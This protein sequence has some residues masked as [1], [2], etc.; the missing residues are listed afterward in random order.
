MRSSNLLNSLFICLFLIVISA[1][2]L[3]HFFKLAP[4]ISLFE[5]RNLAPKPVSQKKFRF[6][7][8]RKQFEP[9]YNDHF[10][11]RKLLLTA[12]NRLH[13]KI[14]KIA[15]GVVFGS[16]DWLF[17]KQGVRS[18]LKNPIPIIKD[19]CGDAPFSKHE[20]DQWCN[21]LLTNW[22]TL[23]EHGIKYLYLP[24]PN[25]HRIYQQKLPKYGRCEPALTRLDQL[26]DHLTKITNYPIIDL[27]SNF[28]Q[29]ANG[30]L[31]FQRDTHWNN[32]GVFIAYQ[33]IVES[34]TGQLP[35]RDVSNS[36]K[37]VNAHKQGCD[38]ALMTGMDRQVSEPYQAVKLTRRLTRKIPN[39]Y[40]GIRQRVRAFEQKDKSLSTVLVFHDSFGVGTFSQLIS[41][42]FSQSIFVE[43]AVPVI[44]MDI[45]DQ[46]KPDIVIHEMVERA[47][48]LPYF[49]DK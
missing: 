31:Y 22:L 26:A 39:P 2:M 12:H 42:S 16:D 45:V 37:F 23:K 30:Q 20:L 43:K 32:R 3:D 48:L 17:L 10:G 47:L 34:I 44:P 35:L 8:F 5:N 46:V 15:D 21:A 29:Y 27:R 11:F 24:V 33:A 36:F 6:K 40:T 18:D 41:E 38:L 1:P 28:S 9:F 4:D 14:F 19:L 25:K 7:R 49:R 13:F